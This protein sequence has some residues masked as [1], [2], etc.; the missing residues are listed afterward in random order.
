MVALQ[1]QQHMLQLQIVVAALYR[2]H[3]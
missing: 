2:K 1:L 3:A